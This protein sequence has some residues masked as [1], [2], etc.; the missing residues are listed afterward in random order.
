MADEYFY[1]TSRAPQGADEPVFAS[2]QLNY[3]LDANAGSYNSGIVR[4]DLS[5]VFNT[6]KHVIMRDAYIEIP[7]V[8]VASGGAGNGDVT[9]V[10]YGVAP[11]NGYWNLI[12]N[13]TVEYDGVQ[14]QQ[15]CQNQQFYVSFKMLTSMSEQDAAILGPSLGFA[16]DSPTSWLRNTTAHASGNGVINSVVAGTALTRAGA[17]AREPINEGLAARMRDTSFNTTP[18]NAIDGASFESVIRPT[19]KNYTKTIA[20]AGVDV[21]NHRQLWFVTARIRLRDISDFWDKFPMTRGVTGRLTIQ[22]NVGSLKVTQA[23]GPVFSVVNSDCQ[24][25]AGVC[26]FK[27]NTAG[28]AGFPATRTAIIVGAYIARPGQSIAATPNQSTFAADAHELQ[29]CRL[30]YPVVEMSPSRALSY[31]QANTNKVITWEDAMYVPMLVP[32]NSSFDTIISNSIQNPQAIVMIPHLTGAGNS[33]ANLPLDP[34]LSPFDSV[35]ATTSPVSI[36]QLNVRV[37]GA[38]VWEQPRTVDYHLFAS[39]YGV[40]SVNGAQELGMGG[41]GLISQLDWSMNYRYIYVDLS[42]RISDNTSYKS[43]S[44]SGTN[45]HAAAILYHVYVISKR[46]TTLNTETGKL[47][48]QVE[49]A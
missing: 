16:K 28:L 36:Q 48:S 25:S 46:R 30:W 43:I 27:I 19:L 33:A 11:V 26:P 2:R 3:L 5:S 29:Q 40:N 8:L 12:N 20:T 32:A 34:A 1:E 13:M 10:D 18:T 6:Q 14:V 47:T 9:A 7:L 4:F 42:R 37:A 15:Q 41:A 23:A 38:N 44:V 45:R 17:Y 49:I 39:Q 22:C 31:A 24:F 21:P 35:P